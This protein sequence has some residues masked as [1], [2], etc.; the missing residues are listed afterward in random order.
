MHRNI[1]VKSDRNNRHIIIDIETELSKK[2]KIRQL[3]RFIKKKETVKQTYLLKERKN[4]TDS[5]TKIF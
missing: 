2:T 1:Y 5:N 4:K 3:R